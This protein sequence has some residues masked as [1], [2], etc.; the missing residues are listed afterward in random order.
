M[1]LQINTDDKKVPNL[2]ILPAPT[3]SKTNYLPLNIPKRP[4]ETKKIMNP[5]LKALL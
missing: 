2:T 5:A 1:L 3:I 4:E